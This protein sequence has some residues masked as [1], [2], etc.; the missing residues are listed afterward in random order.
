MM[1]ILMM[2]C[3]A[4]WCCL[5]GR[6]KNDAPAIALLPSFANPPTPRQHQH[7]RNGDAAAA[8]G[9]GSHLLV[10]LII[11]SGSALL[12]SAATGGLVV[13]VRTLLSIH[14]SNH[15]F[16]VYKRHSLL[17]CSGGTCCSSVTKYCRLELSA[18]KKLK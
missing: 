6:R 5:W 11:C 3:A 2:G 1:I 9:G 14:A 10:V 15:D 4:D 17:L 13:V 12:D 18:S 7:Q 16:T 8:T